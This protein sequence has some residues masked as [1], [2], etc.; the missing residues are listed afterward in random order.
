MTTTPTPSFGHLLWHYRTHFTL[1]QARGGA[2]GVGQEQGLT[3]E[4]LAERA[5]IS[6]N[7]ISALERGEHHGPRRSTVEL[8][9]SALELS[10][11]ERDAFFDAFDAMRRLDARSAVPPD[12]AAPALPPDVCPY[13]GLQ[14]FDEE[15]AAFFFGRDDDVERLVEKLEA[16]P[17]LAVLG[18]SGSG[19][20]SLV[21]AGLLPALRRGALPGSAQWPIYT[22]VPGAHPL[23]ALAA[24]LGH[25]APDERMDATLDALCRDERTLSLVVVRALANRPPSTRVVWVV[26]QGEEVFSLCRDE[27]E[28]HQFLANLLY[29]SAT[30]DSPCIVVLTLRADFYARCAAYPDLARRLSAHQYLV[31]PLE[32]DGLRQAIEEPAR[33]VGLRFR[34]G[35]VETILDDVALQ[36]GALPLLEHA[37]WE[38]WAG[39]RGRTLTLEAYR[40]SGGVQ[41]AVAAR[42]EAVYGAF[43]PARQ[44]IAQRVLLRLTQPGEETAETRRRVAM[45]EL[46]TQPDE[47][48]EV[49]AVVGA[50]VDA[51][52]LTTGTDGARGAQWIEVA[53][54]ALIR[55]WERLRRWMEED[56]EGLRLHRRL[57][58]AARSWQRLGC[59]DG[60]LYR[61]LQLA[62]ALEW[63][64]RHGD[65]LNELERAFLAAGAARRQREED[66]ETARRRRAM[67]AAQALA[68]S[69]QRRAAAAH[70][71]ALSERRRARLA[72]RLSA[73]LAVLLV[74][75]LTA[76]GVAV[77]Q[78][79][80]ALAEQRIAVS[81]ELAADADAQLPL[82]PALSILLASRAAQTADTTQA[83]DALRQA[84]AQSHLRAI[85][86][87]HTDSVASATFSADGQDVLT[88]SWDHTARVWNGR[89]GKAL[90]VLHGIAGDAAYSPNGREIVTGD[91][92]G[93][94]RFWD[95]ATGKLLHTLRGHTDI[96]RDAQFSPSGRAVV[97]ASGDGTAR[98]WDARSGRCIA[99]LRGHGAAVDSALFSPDGHLIVTTAA[100]GTA[101]VWD[102]GSGRAL[103]VLEAGPAGLSGTAVWS[104]DSREVATAAGG[105]T[106]SIWDARTGRLVVVLHAQDQIGVGALAFNHAGTRIATGG[107]DGAVRVWDTRT[108]ALLFVLRGHTGTVEH[109]AFSPDDAS[110]VSSGSDGTA[111]IWGGPGV[112]LA[113]LRGHTNGVSDAEFS[114]DGRD[115][116]TA[117]ADHTARIWQ[118][119]TLLLRTFD[120]RAGAVNDAAFSPDGRQIVAADG[121]KSAQ[122]WSVAS[123]RIVATL[124]GDTDIVAGATFSPDGRY[125][126]TASADGTARL[127]DARSGRLV[128]VM[129]RLGASLDTATLSPDGRHAATAYGDGTVRLWAVPSGRLLVTLRG[130][131]SEVV[132]VDF[133]SDGRRV[134]TGS[135]DDTAR[136]WDAQTGKTLAVLRGHTAAV[137]DA[138]FSPDGRYVA[139]ASA[140]ETARLWETHSGRS[141]AI[142]RGHTGAVT[143]VVFSPDGRQ[144]VT[145]STDRT[146][147]IWAVPSGAL[148]ATLAGHTDAVTGAAFSVDG[149]Y[150]VTAS[151]DHTARVWAAQTGAPIAVLDDATGAVTSVQFSPHGHDIVTASM[152]NMVRLYSCDVCAPVSHLL[153][154]AR[155]RALTLQEQ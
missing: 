50:L 61:G 15:H 65:A 25:L 3:Q 142:L 21:R 10:G 120:G 72:R 112:L 71:L 153:A 56:G 106:A 109:V 75:A 141:V 83:E 82:D 95:A 148:V 94:A 20:S 110:I 54:E 104:P 49:S 146:A 143:G 35:L 150:L 59:D 29:A 70:A 6:V 51:R 2:V 89:T 62:A 131:S 7:T 43:T 38:L 44:A 140:D 77:Q 98:V 151:Q 32:R 39:R 40:A 99:I 64:E 101:R 45:D 139:T 9:A 97:T 113:T 93:T 53:H 123:G 17:F 126:F 69:E 136:L 28:R 12:P 92:D 76:T 27:Q 124:R 58:E 122:I 121:R 74:G 14:P 114:P 107:Y 96:V 129:G 155:T 33:R 125:V 34:E 4:E 42:A 86:Q 133:S 48:A 37:L 91:L 115:V 1:A 130:H 13:R 36:P 19:K 87:G 81:R 41:G 103:A 78:R 116:V 152:D 119:D 47:R 8:L 16:A 60:A 68:Q 66:E 23:V 22:F 67:D 85:L 31:T 73:V 102:A 46:V 52:L 149:R 55:G 147:R 57:T 79:G 128:A 5:G 24:R 84:L 108:G 90:F 117:G 144:V 100:D 137:T 26:D 118:V 134:V 105:D 88:A 154:L 80:A 138:A 127:W 132:G 111:R 11:A 135:W 30:P 63:Q 18:P 145:V